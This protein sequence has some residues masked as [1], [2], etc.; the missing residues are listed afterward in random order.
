MGALGA[1]AGPGMR[2]R[3]QLC[4]G[5]G[6]L[7]VCRMALSNFE[8]V[9]V[10]VRRASPFLFSGGGP[11]SAAAHKPESFAFFPPLQGVLIF[12]VE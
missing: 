9:C 1:A 5:F 7:A 2:G 12:R 4:W 10:C 6:I 8:C 3:F 11:L